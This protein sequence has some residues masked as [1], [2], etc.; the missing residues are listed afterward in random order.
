MGNKITRIE[1]ELR[2]D[3]PKTKKALNER[4]AKAEVMQKAFRETMKNS[5]SHP[6]DKSP[7]KDEEIKQM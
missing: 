1:E 5:N 4:R 7:E 3:I 6:A 2:R